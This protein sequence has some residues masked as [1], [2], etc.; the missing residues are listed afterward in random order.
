[1]IKVGIV[2]IID[3]YQTPCLAL[4][5]LFIQLDDIVAALQAV[6]VVWAASSFF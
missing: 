6:L 3:D 4:R 1:M 5:S 2:K